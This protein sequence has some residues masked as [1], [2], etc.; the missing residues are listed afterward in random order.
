VTIIAGKAGKSRSGS[1]NEPLFT[2]PF[3][4]T[5]N[6]EDGS[7]YVTDHGNLIRKLS[8]IFWTKE[9]H[10]LFNPSIR[11]EIEVVMKM[12]HRRGTQFSKLPRDITFVVIQYVSNQQQI[13]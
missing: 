6:P 2:R 7:I 11:S 13:Q 5:V 10:V 1:A 9:N 8:K 3:G 12:A 4:I